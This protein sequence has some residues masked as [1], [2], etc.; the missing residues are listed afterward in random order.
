MADEPHSQGR[1]ETEL[2][3]VDR[4]LSELMA[5]LRVALPGVQVLFAFLLVVP[6]QPTF[7]RVSGFEKGIY[8]ATL[9]LTALA[10][11]CLIAP[12]MHHRL[13]FRRGQKKVIVLTANGLT[14][15]G[16]SLLALAMS[17]VVLLITHVLFGTAVTIAASTVAVLVFAAL[18]YVIPIGQR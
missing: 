10:A 7:A 1:D 14:I 9:L 2:E 17:G 3:R 4:N 16:L 13:L 15:A 5:E 18:W 8:F 11:A 12:S 6:F